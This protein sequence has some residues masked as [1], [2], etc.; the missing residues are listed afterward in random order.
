[1]RVEVMVTFS[2]T[3]V[4]L[5]QKKENMRAL[6]FARTDLIALWT[7]YKV[8]LQL[9]YWLPSFSLDHG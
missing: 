2:F 5:G 1:M 9:Q 6:T 4:I 8:N 3:V 7:P